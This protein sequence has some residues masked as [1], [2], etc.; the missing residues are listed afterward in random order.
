MKATN[1]AVDFLHGRKPFHGAGKAVPM[2]P[3][4][5][6]GHPSW[7]DPKSIV[8]HEFARNAAGT[9]QRTQIESRAENKAFHLRRAR[10]ATRQFIMAAHS[11]VERLEKQ[12]AE[13]QYQIKE[14]LAQ[15]KDFKRFGSRSGAKGGNDLKKPCTRW[16]QFLFA[17]VLVMMLLAIMNGTFTVSSVMLDSTAFAGSVAK[18][19]TIALGFFLLPGLGLSIPFHLLR[20]HLRW[21]YT[22]LAFLVCCGMTFGFFFAVTWAHTYAIETGNQA[23]ID[24]TMIGMG[25]GSQED[26]PKPWLFE[27]ANWL[28]LLFQIL[29]DMCFAGA[30]KSYLTYLT[31]H[32]HI[33]RNRALQQDPEW[34]ALDQEL[35]D[36]NHQ[37]AHLHGERRRA[38]EQLTD[39]KAEA[40]EFTEAVCA[41][42][43]V[44]FL[45]EI[46]RFELERQLI[47]RKEAEL[48]A[49]EAAWRQSQQ[50]LQNLLTAT[51][52]VTA[53]KGP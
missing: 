41:C 12:I 46:D 1:P 4:D 36:L 7:P 11:V 43:D 2:P 33:F 15:K 51:P 27:N 47:S 32:Y 50:E 8:D 30:A 44:V 22:Y 13:I 16:L 6:I 21:A 3:N 28:S 18:T 26:A 52:G 10:A 35:Q 19:I 37:L 17:T 40:Q 29:A 5:P 42:A 20:S 39:I 24:L 23:L 45:Q 49:K 53:K 48:Q 31:W 34:L 9:Q 38:A 25:S 14:R